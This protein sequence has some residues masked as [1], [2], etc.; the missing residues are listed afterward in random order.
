MAVSASHSWMPTHA[1]SNWRCGGI[2]SRKSFMSAWALD[3]DSKG[4]ESG[5][6]VALRRG[7][8]WLGSSSSSFP[9][10]LTIGMSSDFI[11][12]GLCCRYSSYGFGEEGRESKKRKNGMKQGRNACWG[13]WHIHQSLEI[14]HPPI[15]RAIIKFVEEQVGIVQ[16]LLSQMR[17]HWM[18]DFEHR[19][20]KARGTLDGFRPSPN[21]SLSSERLH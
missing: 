14:R 11:E 6:G 2:V 1:T 13:S 19:A 17:V 4:F 21:Q 18:I 8:F 3:I 9:S 10:S 15:L 5:L 12:V 20:P 7:R 16:Y